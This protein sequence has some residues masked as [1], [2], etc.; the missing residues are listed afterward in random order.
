MCDKSVHVKG[1]Q[2]ESGSSVPNILNRMDAKQAPPTYHRMSKVM[3]GFQTIVDS[4]GVATYREI[5]PGQFR[6]SSYAL[7]S[8]QLSS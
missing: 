8:V 5:N 7:L 3:R 1:V 2:E 6:M 4:Y